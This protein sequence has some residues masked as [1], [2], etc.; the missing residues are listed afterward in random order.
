VRHLH[1]RPC[2]GEEA[3]GP[4]ETCGTGTIDWIT[5]RV[6]Q[7]HFFNGSFGGAVTP[8]TRNVLESTLDFTGAA[9]LGRPRTSSPVISRLRLRTSSATDVEWDLDYDV[10]RGR[11]QASNIFANYRFH[12]YSFS[13]GDSGLHNIGVR[14]ASA[15]TATTSPSA[16]SDFNQL[17]LAAVYGGPLKRGLSAGANLGYDF[18]FNQTQYLGAQAGYNRDC[19]GFTFEVRRYSLGSVRDDTQYLFSFTLAGVGSAGSLRPNIRVY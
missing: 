15:T 14:G 8:G 6:A 2:R 11:I 3:L 12:D 1:A 16:V 9:F 19:C 7:K 5:W 10:K 13:I 4:A 18:T 17:R